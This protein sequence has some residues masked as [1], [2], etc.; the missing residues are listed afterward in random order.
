MHAM[1]G[2]RAVVP[3]PLTQ[4]NHVRTRHLSITAVTGAIAAS[5]ILAN[6]AAAAA[7]RGLFGAAD[8]TYDGVYRQSLSILALDAADAPVPATAIT[9]L[10]S[11]QC[12]DGSFMAYRASTAVP[13]TAPDPAAF[14]GPDSN[15]TALAA[16]ALRAVDR[17]AA[18]NKAV[19][20]LLRSQNAD[21]GW[22]YTLGGASD[23]NST[24]LAAATLSTEQSAQAKAG[25]AART[26]L[27]RIAGACEKGASGLPFQAGSAMNDLASAQALAGI[28]DGLDA[29]PAERFARTTTSCTAPLSTRVARYLAAGITKGQGL[30]PSAMDP[31]VADANTTAWAVLGLV[32]AKQGAAQVRQATKAIAG[33]ASQTARKDGVVQPAAAA[34]LA[35]VAEA[36]DGSA[37]RFGG[38]NPVALITGSIRK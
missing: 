33:K 28:T 14:S 5:L 7:D 29:E 37:T 38:V 18:A 15:S 6:P 27:G 32:G 25:R 12:A 19:A 3:E 17:D 35:L 31:T 11:Q 13:C 2:Q 21:G 4:R 8:P 1:V 10:T 20:A 16:L 23:A 30:L 36:T 34:M 26:Y 22:G 24:G 9:W